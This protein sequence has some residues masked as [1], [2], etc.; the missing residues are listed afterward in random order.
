MSHKKRTRSIFNNII[1][2]T[3][4]SATSAT[5]APPAP[6]K[7][8]RKIQNQP[9]SN[10]ELNLLDIQSTLEKILN[11]NNEINE[12]VDELLDRVAR[13]E[14]DRVVDQEFINVLNFL[15]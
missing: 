9:E 11:Q 13:I 8:K 3:S 5:S 4:A 7:K 14:E 12:K 15:T 10:P 6:S 1:T 2:G